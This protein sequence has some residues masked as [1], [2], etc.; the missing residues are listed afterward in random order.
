[1]THER[2]SP[3]T[4]PISQGRPGHL[5]DPSKDGK[6]PRGAGLRRCRRALAALGTAALLAALLAPSALG[7]DRVYWT[8]PS[9][10]TISFANLDGSGGGGQLSTAGAAVDAPQGIAV[11]PAGGRI[12]W[13][14]ATENKISFA[15]LEGSGGGGELAV[16]GASVDNP[17]GV[18]ID[19]AERRIYWANVGDDT[20]SFASLDGSGGGQLSTAGAT[21]ANPQGVALDLA[22]GRIYWANSGNDTISFASL[23]GSGG[24]QLSTAGATPAGPLGVAI[25]PTAGRIIWSN[26]AND[27]ISFADLDGSGGGGQISTAGAT[28]VDPEGVAIDP[29][30]G[31]IYWANVANDTISFANLDGSGGGAQLSTAGANPQSP[32]FLVLVRAPVG[33]G[34][35]AVSGGGEIGQELTCDQGSWAP[36][37]PGSFLY[38]SARSYA[39]QWRVDGS[40]IV[41]ATEATYTPASPGDYSCRVTATN[42]AGSTAQTSAPRTV[43]G[44]APTV[45]DLSIIELERNRKAGTATLTVATNVP[46]NINVDKT[47]KVKGFGAVTLA[48]AGNGEVVVRPRNKLARKLEKEGKLTVNPRI[49]LYAEN[50][51]KGIRHEFKLRQD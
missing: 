7:A 13:S 40:E 18:A 8:N 37:L 6:A 30:A 5:I 17:R 10:R 21:V 15:R 19:P 44:T 27:T 25:D 33:T 36:D 38:R 20:I 12:Y 34:A 9:N 23:D 32:A 29:T 35:P 48:A 14:D 31:R 50:G 47:K 45:P 43:R 28:V 51:S 46:G 49:R 26:F 42:G 11:D 22:A 41:G 2:P 3:D 16:G 39:H 24:G 1:L 4:W